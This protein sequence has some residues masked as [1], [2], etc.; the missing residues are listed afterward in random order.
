M[1]SS[2]LHGNQVTHFEG[3]GGEVQEIL[4]YTSSNIKGGGSR[5]AVTQVT[6]EGVKRSLVA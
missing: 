2:V 3:G 5:G 1:S 6:L 4:D